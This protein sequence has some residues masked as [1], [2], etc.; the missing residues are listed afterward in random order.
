MQSFLVVLCLF[1]DEMRKTT[2]ELKRAG[3]TVKSR[4][5]LV[6]TE[7]IPGKIINRTISS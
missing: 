2:G 7:F 3:S 4:Q 5:P 6:N 1:P